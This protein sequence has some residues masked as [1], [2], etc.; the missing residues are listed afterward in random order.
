MPPRRRRLGRPPKMTGQTT[1]IA[2]RLPVALL[3]R[4][5]R[6]A[7]SLYVDGKP[8]TR[9]DAIRHLLQQSLEDIEQDQAQT[10]QAMSDL[11][12]ALQPSRRRRR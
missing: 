10:Q 2:F 12:K 3:K 7:P 9:A 4:L 5:D 1:L 6:F 8:A 11:F